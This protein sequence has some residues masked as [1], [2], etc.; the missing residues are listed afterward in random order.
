MKQT[1][2]R[3]QQEKMKTMLDEAIKRTVQS[4]QDVLLK[5]DWSKI[6]FTILTKEAVMTFFKEATLSSGNMFNFDFKDQSQVQVIVSELE[7]ILSKYKSYTE[8]TNDPVNKEL[9]QNAGQQ[10]G[11]ALQRIFEAALA[12]TSVPAVVEEPASESI[13][14]AALNIADTVDRS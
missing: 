11:V 4:Q 9:I 5:Q 2:H 10:G 7:A 1:L 13:S 6:H 14:L 3:K 12:R 8:F